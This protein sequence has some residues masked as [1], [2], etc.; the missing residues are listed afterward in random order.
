MN[1]NNVELF[2]NNQR[3]DL[4]EDESIRIKSKIQDV[5]DIKSVFTDFT[6][7]FT[8]P[9]SKTNNRVLKHI[10]RLDASNTIDPRSY[11]VAR[12]DVNNNVFKRGYALIEKV[13][14]SS[15]VS[16]RYTIRF[17][18]GLVILTR[19]MRD[20]IL[21]DLGSL[22][23]Y[24][25]TIPEGG[26]SIDDL[27][28]DMLTTR[29]DEVITNPLASDAVK[30]DMRVCLNSFDE[31]FY[32]DTDANDEIVD[33]TT[34]SSGNV[35]VV[36][37]NIPVQ[38]REGYRNI[39]Y[40]ND[41][42]IRDRR[43]FGV[44][45]RNLKPS[46]RNKAILEA[47][48]KQYG[49]RFSRGSHTIDDGYAKTEYP[50]DDLEI[51]DKDHFFN[52]EDFLESF[53]LLHNK[54]TDEDL[55]G[56][57]REIIEFDNPIGVITAPGAWGN[58]L[59]VIDHQ[60]FPFINDPGGQEK[61]LCRYWLDVQ[62]E[63]VSGTG[64]YIVDFFFEGG[65]A[66][67]SSGAQTQNYE[68]ENDP[69]Y[70][71][72][73]TRFEWGSF[74]GGGISGNGVQNGNESQGVPIR[75]PEED[76]QPPRY[77]NA[78]FTVR[79]EEGV[80]VRVTATV[81]SSVVTYDG[82]TK[83]RDPI[84]IGVGAAGG[85]VA[86]FGFAGAASTALGAVGLAGLSTGP[87]GVIIAAAI[88]LGVIGL[89]F[90]NN[91]ERN[92]LVTRHV[93][94]T[95]SAGSIFSTA[96]ELPRIKVIDLLS[97]WWK[98]WNLTA[99]VDQD[100]NGNNIIVV[101]ELDEFYDDGKTID[102][103][104]YA[105]SQEHEISVPEYFNPIIF[106]FQE[107]EDYTTEEHNNITQRTYGYG[108]LAHPDDLNEP[109]PDE[110][111]PYKEYKIELPF[112]QLVLTI[113]R[114][115]EN[116]NT[117]NERNLGIAFGWI[118]SESN[119]PTQIKPWIHYI[120]RFSTAQA[121]GFL[122]KNGDDHLQIRDYNAPSKFLKQTA[123]TVSASLTFGNEFDDITG[124]VYPNPLEGGHTLFNKHYANYIS[125]VFNPKA[126]RIMMP[127]R[128]PVRVMEQ[129]GTPSG[130]SNT[131]VNRGDLFRI[132]NLDLN[133]SNGKAMF[134]LISLNDAQ[135]DNP[136]PIVQYEAPLE[137]VSFTNNIELDTHDSNTV[138][139]EVD[140]RGGTGNYVYEWHKV[141]SE[142]TIQ[143]G[144]RVAGVTFESY[145]G[146]PPN[147]IA[148][149][150]SSGYLNVQIT[151]TA[152]RD[153]TVPPLAGS[154]I[155]RNLY[156]STDGGANVVFVGELLNS[157]GNGNQARIRVSRG[158]NSQADLDALNALVDPGAEVWIADADDDGSTT[159]FT[160]NVTIEVEESRN[161]TYSAHNL[162]S[163][164]G[165]YVIVNDGNTSVKTETVFVDINHDFDVTLSVDNNAPAPGDTITFTAE[166]TSHIYSSYLYDFVKNGTVVQSGLSNTYSE[167]IDNINDEGNY[168]VRVNPIGGPVNPIDSNTVN[169]RLTRILRT[170]EGE[171][172]LTNTGDLIIINI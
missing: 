70:E 136:P 75:V 163:G 172:I 2:I 37:S 124:Q 130:L 168:A 56:V 4:F 7:S 17:Y 44:E 25:I 133:T 123:N 113:P 145:D 92:V 10:F 102:I 72:E 170:N 45:S 3:V 109:S 24:Q 119:S 120:D 98:M 19:L 147:D 144:Q 110:R 127:A 8:I 57:K 78:G 117:D 52:K 137:L 9:A 66:A 142:M 150:P 13:A 95:S 69:R 54:A 148:E 1:R 81:T 46:L 38:E 126:R 74:S 131:V 146:S 83:L 89:S 48:E 157:S 158:T 15:G 171:P 60:T 152:D 94:Q 93:S 99:Y 40:A 132:N 34:S 80:E 160:S 31:G 47:I 53:M 62:I 64:A 151:T 41:V 51:I 76:V 104:E 125:E 82:G 14:V 73:F 129:F 84:I 139:F 166:A 33:E 65:D 100:V 55:A 107:A 23:D 154:N 162:I 63:K 35:V 61:N 36:P 6:H 91:F 141:A 155:G 114:D 71:D 111:L 116:V 28:A 112:S 39:W 167:S 26:S 59:Q 128:L 85:V 134:D 11:Q 115:E 87:I 67:W 77:F 22:S 21:K 165:I 135:A 105:N 5:K 68:L 101:R 106:K 58:Q 108:S 159:T 161:S 90:I 86:G 153:D 30:E 169:V 43:D 118:V 103:T 16:N 50:T 138:I 143:G 12:I 156:A 18:G 164:D 79:A 96:D 27:W 42:D 122:V 20:N 29:T 32:Y 88:I 140:V 149:R 121:D 97:G 49:I